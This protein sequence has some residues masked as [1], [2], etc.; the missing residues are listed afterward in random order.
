[1]SP[2]FVPALFALFALFVLSSCIVSSFSEVLAT[3]ASFKGVPQGCCL[4]LFMGYACPSPYNANR[5][6]KMAG[7]RE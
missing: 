5:Q 3:M 1:M 2:D 6:E 4:F 7:E